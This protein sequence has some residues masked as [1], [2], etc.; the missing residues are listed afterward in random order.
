M[1]GGYQYLRVFWLYILILRFE[2]YR[3]LDN[4]SYKVFEL[5]N[6]FSFG[7]LRPNLIVMLSLELQILVQIWSALFTR[8]L[9]SHLQYFTL[10]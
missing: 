4:E 6:R 1:N 9:F 7:I 8:K 5:V 2:F 3:L 10:D